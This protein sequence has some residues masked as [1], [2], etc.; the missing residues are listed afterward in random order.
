MSQL[1]FS[2][3]SKENA[4]RHVIT[5]YS[6]HY[7]KLYEL[8][9]NSNEPKHI[10]DGKHFPCYQWKNTIA[11]L[12]LISKGEREFVYMPCSN[13]EIDKA[14]MR[15]KVDNLAQCERGYIESEYFPD[16]MIDILTQDESVI[17]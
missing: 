14:L 4:S 9:K 2:I 15:L 11:T 12:E 17:S 10:Y 3:G 7:T 8:Y 1:Y 13:A 5:S 6:I 16:R